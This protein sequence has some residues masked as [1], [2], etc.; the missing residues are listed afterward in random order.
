MIAMQQML[1]KGLL[2]ADTQLHTVRLTAQLAQGLL[3]LPASAG[4]G[5][6]TSLGMLLVTGSG[7]RKLLQLQGGEQPGMGSSMGQHHTWQH[8]ATAL[9]GSTADSSVLGD[10]DAAGDD[11]RLTSRPPHAA[12]ATSRSAPDFTRL[13]G[14]ATKH[15]H[16]SSASGLSPAAVPSA[17]PN[18][19]SASAQ[20]GHR[21]E[22]GAG[23]TMVH[24]AV[25]AK[26]AGVC[27]LPG[28]R[29]VYQSLLGQCHAQL[30]VSIASVI[31]FFC[32]QLGQLEPDS[33]LLGALQV[34][35]Q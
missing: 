9:L 23:S 16:S 21:M 19:G 15:M 24:T 27:S 34:R 18:S 12:T 30:L 31:P 17:V 10:D 8:T 20:P 4:A 32:S 3:K 26:T 2:F 28:S 7:G 11:A 14:R 22:L 6:S 13:T 29:K 5:M 25:G 33:E 35:K 1:F